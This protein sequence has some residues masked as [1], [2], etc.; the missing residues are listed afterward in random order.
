MNDPYKI[1]GVSP[2]A[3]DDEIKSAYRALARKYHPDKYRDSDLAEMAGEKMKEINAAYDEIQK[4]RAGRSAGQN[5]GG[6]YGSAYGGQSYGGSGAGYGG[7]YGGAGYGGSTYSGGNPYITARQLI[8]LRRVAEA[9]Q[10]LSTVPETERGA[11]WHFLMGCVAVSRGHFVDAQSF[12]DT[13]CGMDP[14]NPEYR[15]ARERLRN[16]SAGFGTGR[17]TRASSCSC[18]DICTAF[19]CADLCCD[20]GRC[21]C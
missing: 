19:L 3:T 2:T 20:A 7:S 14:D 21:C 12:F 1:L 8:N 17:A 11:E 4:L 16:R 10:V 18:C 15:D 5:A 6:G 9:A 13:A